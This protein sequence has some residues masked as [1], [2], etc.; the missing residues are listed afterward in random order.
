VSDDRNV[1]YD[2]L[3]NDVVRWIQTYW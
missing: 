2:F 3:C 1:G